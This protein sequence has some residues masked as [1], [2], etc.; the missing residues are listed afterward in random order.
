[1]MVR[2]AKGRR[3][4]WLL[5]VIVGLLIAAPAAYAQ[6]G[7]GGPHP[8][9]STPA[10]EPSPSFRARPFVT[11]PPVDLP[12]A[13]ISQKTP[14]WCWA[15]VAQQVIKLRRGKSPPQCALV[16]MVHG[17]YPSFCCP[18]YSR[19][20]KAGSLQQIQTL[21]RNFGRRASS[22]RA[23]TDALSLYRTLRAGDPVI[24][25]LRTSPYS[26]HVVVLKGMSW[27]T[28]AD[29]RPEAILHI[30]DPIHWLPPRLPF[31]SI[32][33]LWEAAIVVH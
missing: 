29:G 7:A 24:L 23:P 27:R 14:V 19:C 9:P 12:I 13:N 21:I 3:P 8:G 26:G 17:R 28:G 6:K 5:A 16:A 18:G 20:M 31:R 1:M 11:P 4:A 33:R 15:A 30:N 22:L 32:L 25:A 10:P 2:G